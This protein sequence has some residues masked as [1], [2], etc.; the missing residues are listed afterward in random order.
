[1]AARGGGGCGG[2][3]DAPGGGCGNAVSVGD[4]ARQTGQREGA[5]GW[6][7][8]PQPSLPA[9]PHPPPCGQRDPLR[10]PSEAKPSRRGRCCRGCSPWCP[11]GSDRP[12][13]WRAASQP[14]E[15]REGKTRQ[16]R[17]R[18]APQF[19][20]GGGGLHEAPCPGHCRAPPQTPSCPSPP[21]QDGHRS[22]AGAGRFWRRRP[23]LGCCP[24]PHG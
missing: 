1:M 11:G 20:I 16:Q 22:P 21:E 9:P 2:V 13:A 14:G 12:A 18:A 5:V 3:G 17:R 24:C 19:F 7:G 8:D 6:V 23:A 4:A 15:G 10:S